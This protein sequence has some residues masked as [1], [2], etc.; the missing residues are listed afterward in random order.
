MAGRLAPDLDDADPGTVFDLASITKPFT[1][2]ALA[3]LVRD[4]L[5]E[6]TT[7]IGV[8]L[9]ES[10]GTPI[11]ETPLEWLASHRSGLDGHRRLYAPLEHGRCVERSIAL[12]Q[13]CL[14]RRQCCG[15]IENVGVRG[16]ADGYPPVYS[17]LGYMLLG[18]ALARASGMALDDLIVSEVSVPLGLSVR[19]ARQ[20]RCEDASFDDRV[21]PTE[22][23]SWRG[24]IVRGAVHDDNAWAVGKHSTCGHAGLFGTALDVTKLGIAVLLA[25]GGEL[26]GWLRPEEIAPL[27]RTRAGGTLR[28]GFDGKSEIGSS[29]GRLCAPE[30]FGHLGFTGTSLWIDP[31]AEVVTVLLTNRVYPN[32]DNARI[33]EARPHVHNELFKWGYSAR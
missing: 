16:D 24:G 3:R 12:R 29:A 32:R 31:V 33:H 21:A 2:L 28:A 30:T 14:S 17:D 10:H 20:W 15:P 19:S 4:G 9:R 7:S 23:V 22:Y 11:A 27:V 18:E 25:R 26:S 13:A 1:A 6:W 5:I 8:L